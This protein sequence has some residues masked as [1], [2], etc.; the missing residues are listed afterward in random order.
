MPAG[1]MAMMPLVVVPRARA[2]RNG[3]R[4]R[5]RS[6]HDDDRHGRGC[7]GA[8]ARDNCAQWGC[9]RSEHDLLIGIGPVP[10]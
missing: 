10:E 7:G 3:Q 2:G 5:G 8:Q 9:L 4:Q 6:E 1:V